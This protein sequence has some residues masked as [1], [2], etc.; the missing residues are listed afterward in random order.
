[1]S[2]DLIKLSRDYATVFNAKDLDATIAFFAANGTLK[3]P[4][5]SCA[6][7]D[8]IRT[9]V[10]GLFKG[11]VE[12]VPVNIYADPVQLTSVIEFKIT[13]GDKTLVGTDVIEWD[14]SGKIK[15]LRAYLY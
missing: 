10:G 4:G 9:L 8:E 7:P 1:M 12:F 11:H 14:E 2:L 3:D 5:A 15:A 6:N 13:I